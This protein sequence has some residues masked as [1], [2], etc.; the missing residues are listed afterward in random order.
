[1]VDSRSVVGKEGKKR[2]RRDTPSG[3]FLLGPLL[4]EETVP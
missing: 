3:E 2:V 1:M 4:S